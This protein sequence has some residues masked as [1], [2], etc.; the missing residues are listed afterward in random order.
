M[1]TKLPEIFYDSVLQLQPPIDLV[2]GVVAGI[3]IVSCYVCTNVALRLRMQS[4]MSGRCKEA[5]TFR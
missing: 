1:S 4:S 2:M 3:P 5:P